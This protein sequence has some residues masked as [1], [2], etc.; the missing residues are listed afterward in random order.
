MNSRST[1]GWLSRLAALLPLLVALILIFVGL[2][3]F[4]LWEPHE[5]DRA[6]LAGALL[7]GE[8]GPPRG[9]TVLPGLNIEERLT[10][11]G[12]RI[13]GRSELTAR[14]PSA[15]LALAAV[16]GLYLTLV[17]LIGRRLAAFAALAFTASPMLLFHGRQ[18]TSGMPALKGVISRASTSSG[19]IIC[20]LTKSA[21][22]I[23][24]S[25]SA[26]RA[27]ALLSFSTR[28]PMSAGL[29]RKSKAPFCIPSIADYR[30]AFPDSMITSVRG[31]KTFISLRV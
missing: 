19:L 18:L 21:L 5:S 25:C 12:W 2:G 6:D 23:R 29:T 7:D 9:K 16:V 13:G 22:R 27:K 1:P 8:D 4:G 3:S 10:A 14:L 24:S 15:L 11:L 20:S 26:F 30:V 17:P 28:S 31:F